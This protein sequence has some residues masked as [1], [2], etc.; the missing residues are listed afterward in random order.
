MVLSGDGAV[1]FWKQMVQGK[2][3]KEILFVPVF[4]SKHKLQVM[5]EVWGLPV[6]TV[7]D[8][9]C[10]ESCFTELRG[11]AIIVALDYW[12]LGFTHH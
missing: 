4:F 2:G 7:G 6:L 5:W 8:Q 11:V 3:E 10:T 1:L 12:H 9:E